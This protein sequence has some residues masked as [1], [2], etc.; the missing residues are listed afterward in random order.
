MEL[1][2]RKSER[3]MQGVYRHHLAQFALRLSCPLVKDAFCLLCKYVLLRK[4]RR[5]SFRWE[6]TPSS[7]LRQMSE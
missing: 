5:S 7:L 2:K 4:S 3:E 1:A 6:E